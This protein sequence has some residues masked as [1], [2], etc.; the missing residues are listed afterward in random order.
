MATGLGQRRTWATSTGALL[1]ERRQGDLQRVGHATANREGTSAD[2][3]VVRIQA[4]RGARSA[5]PSRGAARNGGG[6][7]GR[8]APGGSGTEAG[9]EGGVGLGHLL[10]VVGGDA[11]VAPAP[12][13]HPDALG[14]RRAGT[15]P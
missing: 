14:V 2:G 11:L 3:V 6:G 9:E 4:A 7:P 15:L 13:G 8:L 5:P 12:R 1:L 10:E